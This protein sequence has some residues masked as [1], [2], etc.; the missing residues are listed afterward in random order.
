MSV[1]GELGLKTCKQVFLIL[2]GPGPETCKSL[3]LLRGLG[4]NTCKN[5]R[6]CFYWAWGRKPV[7]PK[8][9]TYLRFLKIL[10]QKASNNLGC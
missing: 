10:G 4:L 2:R 5:L 9:C 3:R 8:T 1:F 6:C 7:K